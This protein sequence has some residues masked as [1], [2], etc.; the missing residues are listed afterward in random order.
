MLFFQVRPWPTGPVRTQFDDMHVEF[1]AD[2]TC[3][4]Q[5]FVRRHALT[6]NLRQIRRQWSL[7]IARAA[8]RR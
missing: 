3:M 6:S 8:L 4:Q 1:D 2:S 7:L 5:H